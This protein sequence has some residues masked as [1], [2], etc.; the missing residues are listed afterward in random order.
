MSY[1]TNADRAFWALQACR[2]FGKQTRQNPEHELD[3]II[4]DLIANL[5]HLCDWKGIDGELMIDH[6]RM[7]HTAEVAEEQEDT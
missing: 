5:L 7:H 1:P 2:E 3:D 4:G 6:G